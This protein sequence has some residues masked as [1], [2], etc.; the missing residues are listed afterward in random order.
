MSFLSLKNHKQAEQTPKIKSRKEIDSDTHQKLQRLPHTYKGRASVFTSLQGSITIEAAFA[1]PFF[2]FASICLIYLLEI[3]AVQTSV[4]AGMHYAC[5]Q[6]AQEA[7][8]M[9]LAIPGQL[10]SDM[11]QAIGAHRLDRSIVVG[12]S[13]GLSA[14][15]SVVIPS[16][17][18]L[19]CVVK[20]QVKLPITIFGSL[21]MTKKEQLKIKGWTGYVKQG[22]G[23]GKEDTVYVT[24]TGVV[25][26][27]DYHCTY[28][29]LSIHM[30]SQKEVE[31]LRNE[32]G[33]KY[34][35]CQRC[36]RGTGG[37]Y[38]TDSGD[39]YHSSLDCSGL[40]RTVYAIAL[41][42]AVG[43]GACSRCAS[44]VK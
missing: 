43:K 28:L 31:H 6:Y 42:E 44:S 12:G 34:A 15:Q 41:S 37:V 3:M 11:V 38:I 18:V 30:V 21:S 19:Q 13:G 23:E 32:S 26:H 14:N 36:G 39:S 9:P 2:L 17:G 16:K 5:K 24:D 8:R 33:G 7:Y 25:Y 40:K 29:E 1:F 27:K 10:E 22:F 20:Y 4:R 35:P